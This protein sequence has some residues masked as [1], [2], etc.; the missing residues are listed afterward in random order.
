MKSCK[1]SLEGFSGRQQPAVPAR[2]RLNELL[3]L[4]VFAGGSAG[5]DRIQA[6]LPLR[7]K[8]LNVEKKRLDQVLS[9]E[10]FGTII[11]ALSTG[12]GNDFNIDNLKYHKVIILSDADQDGAH[13]RAILLTFFFR[14]MK[15]LI[16]NGHLYIG[17]PPLYRVSSGSKTEY[18]YNDDELKTDKNGKEIYC[19]AV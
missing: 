7:G 12:I 2:S 4:K 8:P 14:Y 5:R 3:L 10:E 1:D 17:L 11:T 6:I 18:A 16:T 15:E 19:T 9:N 13:I